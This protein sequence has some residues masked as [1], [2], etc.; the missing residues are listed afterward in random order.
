M[1]KPETESQPLEERVMLLE[2]RIA[3]LEKKLG[4]KPRPART[5]E[6][7][8]RQLIIRLRS[9][10]PLKKPC[11]LRGISDQLDLLGFHTPTRNL[12]RPLR[13]LVR[14]RQLFKKRDETGHWLYS[15]D[16]VADSATPGA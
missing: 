3:V 7:S 9:E 1:Q 12:T 2:E 4:I 16:P 11:S 6:P 13:S 14:E 5:N 10:G 8:V 15:A